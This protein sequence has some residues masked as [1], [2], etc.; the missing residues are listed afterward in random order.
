[1]KRCCRIYRC[2][3]TTRCRS[4]VRSADTSSSTA[5]AEL[6]K[7]TRDRAMASRIAALP[8]GNRLPALADE[9]DP[10]APIRRV[11][12]RSFDAHGWWQTPGLRELLSVLRRLTDL[13]PALADLLDQVCDGPLITVD[14]LMLARVLPVPAHSAC[15]S[16]VHPPQNKGRCTT[17]RNRRL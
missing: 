3:R 14:D 8:E 5:Q 4:T 11:L 6:L 15:G 13:A 7:T 1:M 9:T 16:R 17:R 2:G 12:H 10:E